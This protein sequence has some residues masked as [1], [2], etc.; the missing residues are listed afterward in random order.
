MARPVCSP[1]MSV[2]PGVRIAAMVKDA[3][4]NQTH[5]LLLGVVPQ[6]Q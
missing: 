5:A 6:T 4:E 2:K 1:I 3:V